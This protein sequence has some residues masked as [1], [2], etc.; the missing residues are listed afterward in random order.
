MK[1]KLTF[2]FYLL[3]PLK[4]KKPIGR[5]SNPVFVAEMRSKLF[6]NPNFVIRCISGIF[7]LSLGILTLLSFQ[8]GEEIHAGSV[9]AVAIVFQLGI[10]A[11]LAP[12]ISS[13]LI[14]DEI[15]K[16]TFDALRMTAIHPLTVIAGKFKATFYYALI[17]LLSSVFILL[18]LA[19][20]EQSDCFPEQSMLDPEF[21]S[22][23]LTK[24]RTESDYFSRFWNAYRPVALWVLILLLSTVTFLST[25][26]VCSAYAKNT[27]QATAAAYAITGVL[28]VVTLLPLL[29]AEK[30]SPALACFILSFNPIAVAMQAT[31]DVLKNYPSLWVSNV[32]TLLTLNLLFLGA[33]AFRVSRLF[34]N[35]D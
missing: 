25:G 26:L 33:A 1:R 4:R 13:G 8:M 11:L 34:R 18:A 31:G 17:F 27:P 30:F 23:L 32:I 16:G 22:A 15:T 3:D 9:R 28:C 2:P 6:S 5:L 20:L 12:G 14:T 21:W 35:R 19:Y 10:V 7:V 29:L 24:I